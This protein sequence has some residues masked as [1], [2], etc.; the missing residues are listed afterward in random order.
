MAKAGGRRHPPVEAGEIEGPPQ[1]AATFI[2]S[3]MSL[4]GPLLPRWGTL[5]VAA[6]GGEADILI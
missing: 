4:I 6:F 5:A 3:A 1:L 2:S